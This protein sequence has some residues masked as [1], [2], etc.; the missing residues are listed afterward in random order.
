MDFSK[1]AERKYAKSALPQG[2]AD[3]RVVKKDAHQYVA[4]LAARK[5]APATK[6]F[7]FEEDTHGLERPQT[8]FE[9]HLNTVAWLR[10][11]V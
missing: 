10:E 6:T 5:G 4:A 7:V 3:L 1:F 8:E 2:A 11:H 9:Q